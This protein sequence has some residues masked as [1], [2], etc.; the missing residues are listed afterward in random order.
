MNMNVN[1]L[2]RL[3]REA[4]AANDEKFA[5]LRAL[6]LDLTN[7]VYTMQTSLLNEMTKFSENVNARIDKIQLEKNTHATA[8]P[9]L[10]LRRPPPPPSPSPPFPLV[11]PKG[12]GRLIM[13]AQHQIYHPG[14][15]QYDQT[16]ISPLYTR[17]DNDLAKRVRVE[18]PPPHGLLNDCY[19][20]HAKAHFKAC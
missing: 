17:N 11:E 7:T 10:P 12:K 18:A 8:P 1:E 13:A 16:T 4:Q 2:E 20:C 5:E 3:F 19:N 6:V 9:S 14:Q 15:H